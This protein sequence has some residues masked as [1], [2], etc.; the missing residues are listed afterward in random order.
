CVYHAWRFDADGK[1]LKIPQSNRDG[2]DE[3][4]PSAC[5][6][7][8]PT[9]V[10][11]GIIWVWGNAGPDAGLESALAPLPL[12]P[13]LDDTEGLKEGRVIATPLSV[14]DVPYGWDTMMENI[15][16]PSHV[17]VSH[18]GRAG[19]RY[20]DPKPLQY[21]V[22]M[23][24]KVSL[25][26]GFRL[27]HNKK[28]GEQYTLFKPPV[29]VT[30]ASVLPNGMKIQ[31]IPYATPSRP[32]YT[33]F[34]FRL[35]SWSHT[36]AMHSK[37]KAVSKGEMR[38]FIPGCAR[39]VTASKLLTPFSEA[40][41]INHIQGTAFIHQDMVFLHHQASER[42][43]ADAGVDSSSYKQLTFTPCAADR[44]VLAVRRWISTFGGGG[45][46]WSAGCDT[47]LPPRAT[48]RD[49]LFNVYQHHTKNCK[50]CQ[51]ALKNVERGL[52]AAE[53]SSVLSIA[54]AVLRGARSAA[55]SAP[56]SS[57]ALS[58]A[59]LKAMLPGLIMVGASLA[60]LKV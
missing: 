55:L 59:T 37:D 41:W 51:G 35:V 23:L 60:M 1:C 39:V 25:Q 49:D 33:R 36:L 28:I 12:I 19:N 58:L 54:W 9:K 56:S 24:A 47:T 52:K 15:V 46:A 4:Q 57:S 38:R 13:E 20:T 44:G 34:L 26:D 14:R 40:S 7:V 53:T 8:Y 5:A 43:F 21:P 45:P 27:D 30:P 42:T 18:H 29:L 17:P 16:D 3:A 32:G 6:T 48:N 2:K 50:S 11:Q 10:A 22:P 31:L